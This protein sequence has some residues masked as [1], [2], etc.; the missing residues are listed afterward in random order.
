MDLINKIFSAICY[1]ILYGIIWLWSFIPFEISQ[2]IGRYFS[3]FVYRCLPKR[4]LKVAFEGLK[5]AYGSSISDPAIEELLKKVCAHFIMML[6]ELPYLLRF[7]PENYKKHVI[8]RNEECIINAL[9]K[10]RG[11][12]VLTAHMGNWELMS[13]AVSCLLG[14]NC[15]SVVARPLDFYPLE[16]LISRLRSIQGTEIIP[17]D[18]GMRKILKAAK[19]NKTIGILLDQNVDWYEGVFVPFMGVQ[20]CTNKGL[21][22]MAM[23]NDIPVIPVFSFRRPDGKYE[24]IFENE[25]DI[26]VTGDKQKDIEEN[27][28][29]FTN[30][31]EKTINSH[32]EQWFWFHK[33]WK[34]KPFSHF[35]NNKQ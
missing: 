5:Q 29:K 4:R 20:A 16:R 6:F 30:I 25:V 35:E 13:I 22:I 8:M 34:T 28:Y 10:G 1:Y 2:R 23:A 24:I 3:C 11:C 21:A 31:I 26:I 18:G 12:F 7:S 27:T 33:R 17:K 9:N 14:R 32:P 19:E 15:G